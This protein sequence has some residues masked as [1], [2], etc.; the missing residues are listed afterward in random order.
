MVDKVEILLLVVSIIAMV[1]CMVRSDYNIVVGLICYFYWNSRDSNR[2]PWIIIAI[3]A[4]T[5]IFDI[6]WTIIVWKSWTSKNWASPIWNSLRSLHI[7]VIILTIVNMV[8]K[9][10]AMGLV[11][12]N[13]KKEPHSYQDMS[14]D[15]KPLHYD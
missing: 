9:L 14:D 8:V 12:M 13:R 4:I 5:I 15:R 2:I 7:V 1:N 10:L 11:Y 6:V 3:L